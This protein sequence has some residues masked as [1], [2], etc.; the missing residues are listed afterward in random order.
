MFC[1]WRRA[2]LGI[3]I[4]SFCVSAGLSSSAFATPPSDNEAAIVER[5]SA[6]PGPQEQAEISVDTSFRWLRAGWIGWATSFGVTGTLSLIIGA[7]TGKWDLWFTFVPVYGPFKA[8]S[9][10]DHRGI[11]TFSVVS[12]VL[13]LGFGIIAT[14]ATVRHVG[15]KRRLSRISLDGAT[16]PGG[17]TLG[18]R[19]TF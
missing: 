8:A 17:A 14:L 9:E 6:A 18:A 5:A 7:R 13:R 12:G 1:D 19:V 3:K 4:A 16:I 11:A 2:A 10:L 15:A